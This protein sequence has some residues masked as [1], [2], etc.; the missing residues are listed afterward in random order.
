[1]SG[2]NLPSNFFHAVLSVLAFLVIV[3]I[4]YLPEAP[5]MPPVRTNFLPF[6][7]VFF[8]L[9][10][11]SGGSGGGTPP[12]TT[13]SFTSTP[14]T[15]AEEATPYSY[16]LAA[17]SPDGSAVTF[18]LPTAPVGAT[19]TGNTISWTP[20]HDESRTANNFSV[21]ASNAGGGKA[22]QTWTVT[23]TGTINITAI[24]TYWGLTGPTNV[25]P[26]WNA[27]LP[28]PAVLL[29][30]SDGTF[31]TLRG[32]ANADGSFSIPNVPAGNYWLQINPNANYWTATSDFDN[33]EDL[34][35]RAPAFT[36]TT[37]TTFDYTISGLTVS[38][39]FLELDVLSDVRSA[40]LLE[41]AGS[42]PQFSS[43]YTAN[44]PTGS[45]IDWSKVST[46]YFLQYV[47]ES[48]GG[49]TG[50]VLGPSLTQSGI[51]LTNAAT[52]TITA[53]LVPSPSAS[54]PLS[55]QGTA[56]AAQ[57]ALS[58]PGNPVPAYA[59][60]AVYAQPYVSDRFTPSSY[61]PQGPQFSLLTPTPQS[62][63]P[64]LFPFY[65]C[66]ILTGPSYTAGD[67][68]TPP[69][70]TTDVNYGTLTYGDPF[71]AA[72][73]SLFQY[74]QQSQVTLP[75]PNSSATDIFIATNQQTTSLP[76]G[77]VAPILSPVQNPT[78]NGASL[79]IAA[80]LNTTK[81]NIGWT[82][83]ATGA[84]F[85]YYVSVYQLG[86]TQTPPASSYVAAGRY[87]T[88]QTSLT[89]PL[90]SPNNTYVFTI[91]ANVDA[92]ASI[93]KAPLRS[94]I[95]SAQAGVVSATFTIAPGSTYQ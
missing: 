56:W 1:V 35:G 59:D 85:G 82:A 29:P 25:A 91:T 46:L 81:V 83:P 92:V 63:P 38:N 87:G 74:C 72:W 42:G 53:A 51:T 64:Q 40:S 94:N 89:V 44:L 84:P 18:T 62:N 14:V 50:L 93:D 21:T 33:G 65:S 7:L 52:N 34:Y 13:P 32:A 49:F 41:M 37:T 22:T 58:G 16:T 77:A 12:P 73:L 70:I 76:S 71:P 48:S 86:A 54:L 23:P 2:A 47:Q 45:V 68:V 88:T 24:T 43:T 15:A 30:K 78:L 75:R 6:L 10:C 95:P 17:T 66:G 36:P 28:Y 8:L 79:F 69:A 19:L 61:T 20:T 60:Y 39:N 55:I 4:R 5:P 67:Y 80:T 26:V 3:T 57:A 9:G 31:T 90:L 11:G 27:S